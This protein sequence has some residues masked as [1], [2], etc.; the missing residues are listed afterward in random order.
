M[1]LVLKV[2]AGLAVLWLVVGTPAFAQR[3]GKA[4][5]IALIGGTIY[6]SPDRDPIR[7]GVVL[8]RDGAIAAVDRRASATLPSDVQTIDC[9]GLT[10]MA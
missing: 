1:P 4:R 6:T 5:Q 8:V 7:D 3:A 10:I 2:L 9:S